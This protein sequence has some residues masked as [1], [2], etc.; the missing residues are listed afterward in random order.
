MK[1]RR[2]VDV[3]FSG[4]QVDC[5]Y[6]RPFPKERNRQYRPEA[7]F[8]SQGAAHGERLRL[9]LKISHVHGLPLEYGAPRDLPAR[10]G[11]RRPVHCLEQGRGERLS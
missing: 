3:L 4:P 8:P 9:G 5:A 11:S 10:S 7:E 2:D 6:R 1:V